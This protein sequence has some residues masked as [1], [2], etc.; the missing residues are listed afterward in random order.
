MAELKD[1]Y[2][3]N[4]TRGTAFMHAQVI[5]TVQRERD[6]FQYFILKDF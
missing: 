2:Q 6:P 5:D 1:K 3:I 4:S